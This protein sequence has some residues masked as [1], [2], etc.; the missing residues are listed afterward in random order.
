M[1]TKFPALAH[2]PA[3]APKRLYGHLMHYPGDSITQRIIPFEKLTRAVERHLRQHAHA[4]SRD[5]APRTLIVAGRPGEG[6]SEGIL[7]AALQCG[8]SVAAVSASLFA[9]ENEGGA[10]EVLDELLTELNEVADETG[11]PVALCINDIDQSILSLEEKMG[12]TINTNLLSESLHFL[13][14]NPRLYR[15]RHGT[16]LAFFCTLNDATNLR[17]SLFREGRATWFEHVPTVEDKRNI[18]WALLAPGTTPERKLVDQLTRR[19]KHQSVAFWSSLVIELR[20][21]AAEGLM[22]R[23]I[24]EAEAIATIY[25]AR[26]P[27]DPHLVWASVRKLA[28]PRTRN[29]LSR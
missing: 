2:G 18:A 3:A 20:A 29:W 26:L 28:A 24:G 14:D 6:K 21:S 17:E 15:S 11:K 27:L 9:S 1:T 22:G 7:A 8:W 23:G 10:N 19:F 13:A 12:K 5:T 4:V 16:N 25:G